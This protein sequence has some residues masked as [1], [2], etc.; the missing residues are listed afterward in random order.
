[1]ES[2]WRGG[3]PLLGNQLGLDFL[4]TRPVMDGQAVE[5][6]PDVTALRQWLRAAGVLSGAGAERAAAAWPEA[7]RTGLDSLLH[8]RES[9][10]GEVIRK[11]SGRAVSG[12]F[13]KEMNGLLAEHPLGQRVLRHGDSLK[14]VPLFVPKVLED[15]FAPL[16]DEVVKLFTAL[17]WD[18]VRQCEGCVAHFYDASKKGTRRWCS[19]QL[20]GN[21]FKV[22]A[23][24]HR[25]HRGNDS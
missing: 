15:T 5:L 13:L 22:A 25:K 8:F 6:I 16:L 2:C 9:L 3:F 4:N 23:Y 17:D 10:R 11:E 1:M 24:Y 14:R 7:D 19:M 12:A 18:R 20:C 21:R